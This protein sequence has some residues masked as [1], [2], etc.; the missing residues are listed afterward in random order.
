MEGDKEESHLQEKPKQVAAV[1]S[2]AFT[3]Q[4]G[5]VMLLLFWMKS[6]SIKSGAAIVSPNHVELLVA[7]MP[8]CCCGKTVFFFF[9]FSICFFF[10][11]EVPLVMGT[12][13]RLGRGSSVVFGAVLCANLRAKK[14]LLLFILYLCLIVLLTVI[15]LVC[16]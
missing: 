13:K 6:V 8:S 16:N 2:A 7:C 15:N 9:L 11:S 3:V 4:R 14:G 1:C 5:H 10:V 12:L